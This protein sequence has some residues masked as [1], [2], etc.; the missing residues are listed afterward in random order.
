M[1]KHIQQKRYL[2]NLRNLTKVFTEGIVPTIIEDL[3][4]IVLEANNEAVKAY[5]W[6]REELIGKPIKKI[7]PE[8]RHGQ[9]EE[10]LTRC[11]SGETVRNIDG[12]RLHKDGTEIPVLLTLSLL[13]DDN[14]DPSGI[15]TIAQDMTAIKKLEEDLQKSRK[16]ESLG[17]LA[18]GI[19][20]EFNNIL[21]IILGNAELAISDIQ[22]WNPA[23]DPLTEIKSAS[24]RAKAIIRKFMSFARKNPSEKKPVNIAEIIDESLKFVRATIPTT[25]DIQFE[26]LCNN[27]I[28]NADATEMN[29]VILNMC[30]NAAHAIG[31]KVG[32]IQ[33]RLSP[34]DLDYRES[35]RL[36]NMMPGKYVK[37]QIADNGKGIDSE[38]SHR[39]FDP[40]FTT[41]EVNKG[42]GMGLAVVHG[43]VKSHGGGI[44][45][46]S[47]I[48]NGSIFT[49]L[50]PITDKPQVVENKKDLKLQHGNE[51]ILFIDDEKSIVDLNKKLLEK[52]GYKV[53]TALDPLHA[54]SIF[55]EKPEQF[56]LV[57]TDMAMPNLSGADLSREVLRINPSMKIIL[58]TGYS[59]L[60]GVKEASKIGISSYIQKPVSMEELARIV[61]D[62]LK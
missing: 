42:L 22:E 27:E 47:R 54:L 25:I 6:S 34:E 1:P 36:Q 40:Y 9:A 55:K 46:K 10:L 58:C 14:G 7:V 60:V 20:H 45:V 52:L 41:K 31:S 32:R 8:K 21:G 23:K 44:T 61:Q 24:L 30:S 39:I 49:I 26:D 12:L 3:D 5:G 17:T 59:D 15:V 16:M 2:P 29:Q 37:L 33:I 56:D 43:I 53:Q 18:G 62:V 4:G 50:L 13:T 48:N 11:C 35:T 51:S 57:I 38:I 19:A 28:V